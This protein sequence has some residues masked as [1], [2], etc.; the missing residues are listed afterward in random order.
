MTNDPLKWFDCGDAKLAWSEQGTGPALLLIHGWPMHA[1]TW[2]HLV[3]LLA[4]AHRVVLIDLAG[5]GRSRF[6]GTTDMSF[7]AHATRLQAFVDA[8]LPGEFGCLASDTG[9][10]IARHLA[11][12]VPRL[13]RLLLLNTEI[14]GHRPPWI[15]LF[16]ALFGLP[17]AGLVFALMARSPLLMRS[18]MG[19]GGT[20]F[21]RR[22]IGGEF[23]RLF[24]APLQSSAH[25]REGAMRYLRGIRWPTVDSL[26]LIHPRLRC[27]V[28][29]VWGAD[30][31]T[32]PVAPA[33]A[34]SGQFVPPARFVE[35]EN[36]R[37]LVH[38]EHPDRVAAEAL[39]FFAQ[40]A[41]DSD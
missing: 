29:M 36:A 31:P 2:R 14:P 21:D 6:G 25:C 38:E 23:Q 12:R 9:G 19:F 27:R 5:L 37:L 22:L 28:L 39:R 8:H 13:T 15:R 16:Q 30:D 10:T 34:M 18:P 1:Q 24:I 32:F 41:P 33:R 26:R 17:G 4:P 11:L 7:E 20:L 40:C 35:I 3:P